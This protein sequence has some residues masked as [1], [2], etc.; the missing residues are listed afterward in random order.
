MKGLKLCILLPSV[1]VVMVGCGSSVKKYDYPPS[2]DAYQEI[3]NLEQQM[4]EATGKQINMLAPDAMHD[5]HASLVDAKRDRAKGRSNSEILKDL[6]YARA[7][8]DRAIGRSEKVRPQL[9]EVLTARQ[10]ALQ[11]KA[12]EYY[13]RQLKRLDDDFKTMIARS[14][15]HKIDLDLKDKTKLARDYY[16]LELQAIRS[17][18]LSEV[19]ALIEGAEKLGAKKYAPDALKAAMTKRENAGLIIDTE[20]HDTDKVNGVVREA[21]EAARNA[22]MV[23][24]A[25]RENK[26]QSNEDVAQAL[27]NNET[28]LKELQS[29]TKS[30]Q[31]QN[32]E[33]HKKIAEATQMLD[34][35][36]AFER[37][38]K[39]FGP[40]DADVFRQGN[41]LLI[42]LKG[43]KFPVG[44][45]EIPGRSVTVLNKVDK[46]IK[47]MDPKKVI[48]EG[49][50]D[51]TGSVALN[52]KLSRARA[53]AI[54]KFLTAQDIVNPDIV[55]AKGLGFQK[56]IAS[57]RTR[58]GRAENRRIDI[59]LTPGK[60]VQTSE[61]MN[62]QD[63]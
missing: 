29:H 37:A 58:M 17:D 1:A 30:L 13:G 10:K 25:A 19:D 7:Y 62:D 50:T 22:L 15:R 61:E 63:Q 56:P 47:E 9:I 34:L 31:T 51:S 8:L 20:R 60:A 42:R 5:A 33:A 3:Q 6:G 18:K 59:W 53:D 27:V 40:Q 43:M 49:H 28:A 23:A 2:T 14:E 45:A 32:M 16:S 54:A 4:D 35:N 24:R 26:G 57:N 11:S 46:V 12:P 36:E 52:R 39:I 41:R 44:R 55:T 21:Y 38:Q 48:V